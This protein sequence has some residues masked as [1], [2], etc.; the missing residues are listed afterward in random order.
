ML[1]IISLEVDVARDSRSSG[2]GRAKHRD[3]PCLRRDRE[4]VGEPA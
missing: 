3:H 2:D 4:T 1:G